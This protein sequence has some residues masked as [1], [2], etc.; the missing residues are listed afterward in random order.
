MGLAVAGAAVVVMA[1]SSAAPAPRL[2]SLGV[3]A[4]T[5]RRFGV[6][7]DERLAAMAVAVV[8]LAV[9][10]GPVVAVAVVGAAALRHWW[11]GR[12]RAAAV[13]AART[14][15]VP[16]LVELVALALRSGASAPNAVELVASSEPGGAGEP[17]AAAHRRLAS[18][19]PAEEAFA[20]LADLPGAAGSALAELLVAAG[21]QGAP[22][23][24]AVSDLASRLRA[25]RRRTLER[26][27]QRLPVL[28][29]APLTLC[30]LP[31]FVLIVC[32]PLVLTGLSGLG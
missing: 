18:G 26:R 20:A 30:V 22:V 2:V 21:H 1:V 31:S 16:E 27:V 5:R 4:P 28:L 8:A 10:L 29:L 11:A 24:T 9:V 6:V 32:V 7:I 17:F 13:N 25:D 19:L 23:A 14:A 12:R 3:P 15:A